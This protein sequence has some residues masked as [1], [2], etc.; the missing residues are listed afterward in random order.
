M[1]NPSSTGWI[2]KFFVEQKN[3]AP[4]LVLGEA[5]FYKKLRA[6]GIVFGHIVGF[7]TAV[8]IDLSKW[9]QEEISKVGLLHCL[10]LV[11]CRSKDSFKSKLF[12]EKAAAFYRE[13]NPKRFGFLKR[14]LPDNSFSIDL[15]KM[16]DDRVQ[17]NKNIVSKNFSPILTNA[18]LFVD[19]LAFEKFL[20]NGF[21]PPNYTKRLEETILSVILLGLQTKKSNS[22][23]AD[24]LVKLFETSVRYTKFSNIT[25]QDLEV[26]E[27]DHFETKME[28]WYLIDLAGLSIWSEDWTD[29]DAIYLYQM[30][31]LMSISIDDVEESLAEI[32]AFITTNKKAIPYFNYA[33]PMK[34][35]YDHAS[36][37]V[38]LLI[39]RN[40][41]RLTNEL[42]KNGELVLLLTHSTHRH[43][44]DLEKKKIKKQLLEICKTIPSL[45]IFMLPGGSLLLPLFIKLLPKML[46]ESFN[47]NSTI[48]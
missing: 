4:N 13:M 29:D 28:K 26:L 44:E 46:P 24:L 45:T 6:T 35:F 40:K 43:L 21:I 33:N 31:N 10:F 14:V 48:D 15:E 8:S 17:T 32:N 12:I 18:L 2:D 34:N 20:K 19:V 25:V 47:E 23:Y 30:A 37:K 1:I 42:A 36:Q 9:T 22:N 27:L 7:E 39:S 16:I 41:I 5:D 11:F 38:V 3:V